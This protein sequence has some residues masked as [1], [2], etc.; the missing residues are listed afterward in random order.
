MKGVKNDITALNKTCSKC[1]T[2]K[3]LAD[4]GCCRRNGDMRKSACKKCVAVDAGTRRNNNIDKF[5]QREKAWHRLR[6]DHYKD[7]DRY[8]RH[9]LLP[10][11]YESM[12]IGQMGGCAICNRPN[13]RFRSLCIDHDHNSNKIR[14]LL[15]DWCNLL[16]GWVEKDTGYLA[17]LGSPYVTAYAKTHGII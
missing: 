1:R 10:R 12:T 7:N 16:I 11:D 8:R 15:C 9:G 2:E 4:F 13:R 5:R 17:A 14:G 3:P 6:I